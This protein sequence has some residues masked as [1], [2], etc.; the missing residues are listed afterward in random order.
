MLVLPAAGGGSDIG[1]GQ[2][3]L[4]IIRGVRLST[5][6]V[7]WTELDRVLMRRAIARAR[8]AMGTTWPNPAV[9]CVITQGGVVISEAATQPG[10]RPHAEAMALIAAGIRRVVVGD[11][12]D[13]DPRVSGRGVARLRAAGIQ[14]K[15]GLLR[16]EAWPAHA[17]LVARSCSRHESH[18]G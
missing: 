10:G 8:A 11:G 7:L 18:H 15:T 17:E 16:D 4:A 14:V 12:H 1:D 9:G 5:A 3:R 2:S 6:L 13:P